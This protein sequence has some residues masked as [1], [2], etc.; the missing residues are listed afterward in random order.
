MRLRLT[1]ANAGGDMR[2]RVEQ[3]S[4]VWSDAVGM[5]RIFVNSDCQCDFG[6]SPEYRCGDEPNFIFDG[7]RKMRRV[8][9]ETLNQLAKFFGGNRGNH[10]Q[11]PSFSNLATV[12]SM[13]FTKTGRPRLP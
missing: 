8:I 2:G 10:S 6:V 11:V 1:A 7:R 13:P 5:T 3:A 12:R 4:D 9:N